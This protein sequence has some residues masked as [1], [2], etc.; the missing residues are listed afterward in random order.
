MRALLDVDVLI[1]L[2]DGGH[3]HNSLAMAWLED[4]IQHGCIRIMSQPAYPGA[5]PTAQI[6][7]RLTEAATAWFKSG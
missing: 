6:A 1:A 2:L 3:L 7:E 5:L 4:H